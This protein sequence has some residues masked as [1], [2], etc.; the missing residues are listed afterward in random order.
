[1]DFISLHWKDIMVGTIGILSMSFT[2][3]GYQS[4]HDKTATYFGAL[5]LTCVGW[6][7]KGTIG[8]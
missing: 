7:L 8:N 5:T 4:E 3:A 2:F 6:F 1:M